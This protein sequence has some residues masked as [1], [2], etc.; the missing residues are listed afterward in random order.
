[1]V[2]ATDYIGKT[3]TIH[4]DRPFHTKH[5][6]HGFVYELNYGYVPQTRSPDGEALDAYLIGVEYPVST[7]TG[8]C[9]AIIHRTN[10]DDDKLIVVPEGKII[11]DKEILK[12]THF[13]EKFFTGV[14]LRK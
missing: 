12:A 1:M 8:K 7:F 3:V 2:D 10:D 6:T 5:P 11:S 9:I 13:Q 14:I 4:V